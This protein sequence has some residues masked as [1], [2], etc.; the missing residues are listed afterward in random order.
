M[1]LEDNLISWSFKRQ[2]VISHSS[3]EDEYQVVANGMAEAR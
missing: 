1:F 3:A 2:P